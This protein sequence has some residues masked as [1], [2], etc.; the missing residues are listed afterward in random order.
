MKLSPVSVV[1]T[2]DEACQAALSVDDLVHLLLEAP[3]LV[4]IVTVCL[5]QCGE[6]FTALVIPGEII[7]IIYDGYTVQILAHDESSTARRAHEFD[8][9]LLV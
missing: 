4:C 2:D 3:L 5:L 6:P 7:A 1:C 8:Y 9:D